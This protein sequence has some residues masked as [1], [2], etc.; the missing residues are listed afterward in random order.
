MS[1]HSSRFDPSRG[2]SSDQISS[3]MGSVIDVWLKGFAALQA[4]AGRSSLDGARGESVGNPFDAMLGPFA[5]MAASL[6]VS[7]LDAAG[8]RKGGEMGQAAISQLADLS[9]LVAQA[10]LAAAASAFR[11]G[12][13]IAELLAQY[14]SSL[15][16]AAA[17]RAT[18]HAVASPAECRVLTDE[19]RAFLRQVGDAAMQEARRLQQD[20]EVVGESIARTAGDATPTS[21]PDQRPPRRTHRVKA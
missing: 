9:P 5:D 11:Y 17:D 8:A 18:G 4:M 3:L 20:L 2:G 16:Q 6:G 13:A 1:D 7:G 12:R 15:L 21:H 10:G 14:Q 19:L